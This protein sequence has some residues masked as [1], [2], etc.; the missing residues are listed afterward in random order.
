MAMGASRRMI[1]VANAVGGRGGMEQVHAEL[2]QHLADRWEI[3]VV[4]TKLDD[5]LRKIVTWYRV[6]APRR[7][8]P[9]RISVFFIL[10]GL[11]LWAVRRRGDVVQTC[12][13]VIPNRVDLAT[14]H[15]CHAGMVAA[16]GRL[17]PANAP[18][19]RRVNT[20]TK[21]LLAMGMERWCYRP[22]R[23]RQFHAV[24]Q[25][26]ADEL[27][28]HY[29]GIP[30]A[31]IPN[32]IDLQRFRPDEHVR[33]EMRRAYQVGNTTTVAL[34]VGGDWDRKGLDLAV[35]GVAAA[36]QAGVDVGL[37]VVGRGDTTRFAALATHLGIEPHVR[38][39]CQRTDVSSFYQGADL[40]VLP[41]QYETFSLVSHEAAASGLPLVAT[42]AHGVADLLG[43]GDGG[44]IVRPNS[45]EI[46]AAI[47]KFAA[48]P[49]LRQQL[50]LTA[51]S[52]TLQLGWDAIAHRVD[53]LLSSL[54]N[55]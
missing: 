49:G 42:A 18:L 16:E 17:A 8:A 44:A 6:P 51:R 28:Q 43:D 12:G 11:R 2:I 9:L 23:M 5:S 19:L 14:I 25:G 40:F 34:F 10:A 22:G 47:A 38:F 48:D 53:N 15:F 21:R 24:S 13:A 46:G 41:S 35:R 32:G 20:G 27:A 7:P 37:W 55:S 54:V 36:R 4:S 52:R 45:D 50:G 33:L 26:V 31:M 39:F 1:V 3:A 30:V 29:P